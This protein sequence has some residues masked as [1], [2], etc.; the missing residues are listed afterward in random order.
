MADASEELV[1]LRA[2]N[3]ALRARVA[4][5]E[6]AKYAP[7]CARPL[8]A[9]PRDTPHQSIPMHFA[10][11][12]RRPPLRKDAARPGFHPNSVKPIWQS[13]PTARAPPSS[14]APKRS[15]QEAARVAGGRWE[16]PPRPYCLFS[17]GVAGGAAEQPMTTTLPS[18]S[19]LT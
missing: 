1:A 4:D 14:P 2:E 12:A 16:E 15:S 6:A 17:T 5:L 3:A 19:C 18:L 10:D 8:L 7:E 13:R 9:L 11:L